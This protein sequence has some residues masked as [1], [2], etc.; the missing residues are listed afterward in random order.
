MD[1]RS[2]LEIL[3][4]STRST[5]GVGMFNV[6]A[7]ARLQARLMRLSQPTW[8]PGPGPSLTLAPRKKNKANKQTISFWRFA[9]WPVAVW[10]VFVSEPRVPSTQALSRGRFQRFAPGNG[11][12]SPWGHRR[13]ARSSAT[14]AS[15]FSPHGENSS[16]RGS[17]CPRHFCG[18]FQGS[19]SLA[20]SPSSA[21]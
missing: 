7:R 3:K 10:C 19:V 6:R 1:T 14:S 8:V 15:R 5:S 21:L 2:G 16:Q 9:P 11:S 18:I 13:G 20:R 4:I 12:R 17:A